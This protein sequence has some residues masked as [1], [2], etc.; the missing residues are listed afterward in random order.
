MECRFDAHLF[1]SLE[2]TAFLLWVSFSFQCQVELLYLEKVRFPHPT[3]VFI[4]L[5]PGEEQ[6]CRC[7]SWWV[8]SLASYKELR[9]SD[10]SNLPCPSPCLSIPGLP[11]ISLSS[12]FFMF[13][14]Q[15]DL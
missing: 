11:E 1:L 3:D 2:V 5:L 7:S 13:M 10:I 14:L 4:C 8:T 9:S 12:L 6:W 15:A